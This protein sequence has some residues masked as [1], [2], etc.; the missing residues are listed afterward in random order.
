MTDGNQDATAIDVDIEV[1]EEP[2]DELGLRNRVTTPER[3]PASRR[4][5]EYDR[6]AGKSRSR[7]DD[8]RAAAADHDGASTCSM[9]SDED[10]DQSMDSLDEID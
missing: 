2:G 9:A 8:D 3:P 4:P 1:E 10:V 7:I 5:V 6:D